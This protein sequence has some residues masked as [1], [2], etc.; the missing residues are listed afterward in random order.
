[1]YTRTFRKSLVFVE[2]LKNMIQLGWLGTPTNSLPSQ[3]SR[4]RIEYIY[5]Q[6]GF[7][8]KMILKSK[9]VSRMKWMI[10]LFLQTF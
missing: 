3:L 9:H 2:F 5:I 4:L 10:R 1:M 8:M 7:W 6:D